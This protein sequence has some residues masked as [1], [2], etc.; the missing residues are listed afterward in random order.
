MTLGVATSYKG[1][2]ESVEVPGSAFDL[3][4]QAKTAIT[5]ANVTYNKGA[6][7][8]AAD[9]TLNGATSTTVAKEV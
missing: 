1:E 9:L 6:V 3:D 8:N 7:K 4:I 2:N 5:G